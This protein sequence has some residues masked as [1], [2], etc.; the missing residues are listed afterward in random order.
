MTMNRRNIVIGSLALLSAGWLGKRS[1]SADS[2]TRATAGQ[3]VTIEQFAASGK[4]EGTTP[5]PKLVKTDAEWR[6]QLSPLAFQVARQAGTEYAFSG[7]YDKFDGDGVFECV[8]CGTALFDSKT[9]F[10]SGTGW[11]SFF[12]P[13]SHYNVTE[14]RDVSFGMARVAVSCQ[15]CDAHLGHV[16]DDGPRPTGLRYCMNSVVL[17][18]TPRVA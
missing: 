10:E 7:E 12:R 16:F 9:K 1:R 14:Q 8:C 6:A 15:L 3:I 18:F 2:S 11:P 13:I 4:S 5:V 17:H